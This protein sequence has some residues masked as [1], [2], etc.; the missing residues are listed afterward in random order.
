[1]GWYKHTW[2][3]I[4]KTEKLVSF[5]SEISKW[6]ST[7]HYCGKYFKSAVF[8]FLPVWLY[9]NKL[10]DFILCSLPLKVSKMQLWELLRIELEDS[11]QWHEIFNWVLKNMWINGHESKCL[12]PWAY[13]EDQAFKKSIFYKQ[14][15]NGPTI[16]QLIC[17]QECKYLHLFH[18]FKPDIVTLNLLWFSILKGIAVYR[19]WTFKDKPTEPNQISM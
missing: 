8:L 19:V 3:C 11:S 16:K 13:T 17:Q 18:A 12:S 7:F 10:V 2:S 14:N 9:F 6:I 1:M 4:R 5:Q 15:N